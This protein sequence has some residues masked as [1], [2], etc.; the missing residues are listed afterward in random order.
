MA[1]TLEI[2][3]RTER[4]IDDC[5]G[6]VVQ[7]LKNPSA[8]ESILEDIDAAY[9]QLESIPESFAFCSDPY[10]KAKGY[11]KYSLHKHDYVFIYRVEGEKVFLAGF[12]HM[13]QNYREEL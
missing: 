3:E 7:V 9:D 11:R 13:L 4:Q 10:L 12:F 6:Y 1:Y 2:P 8:A 5:I